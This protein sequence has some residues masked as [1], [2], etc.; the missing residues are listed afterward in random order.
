[1]VH[2]TKYLNHRINESSEI[3]TLD[4]E[5]KQI[6]VTDGGT[7]GYAYPHFFSFTARERRGD[8][9]RRSFI[10]PLLEAKLRPWRNIARDCRSTFRAYCTNA[11]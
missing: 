5:E 4:I 9:G 10:P 7:G 1:M 11:A 2:D 8:N 3:V 6:G